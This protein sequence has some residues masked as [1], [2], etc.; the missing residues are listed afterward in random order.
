[1][2]HFVGNWP[3]MQSILAPSSILQDANCGCHLRC[4]EELEGHMSS[5]NDLQDNCAG[6]MLSEQLF[7]LFQEAD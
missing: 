6:S 2:I 3:A 7:P 4:Q 5:L 1:M